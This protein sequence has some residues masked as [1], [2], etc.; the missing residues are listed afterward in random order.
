MVGCWPYCSPPMERRVGGALKRGDGRLGCLKVACLCVP[1]AIDAASLD[2][3]T[4]TIGSGEGVR[5][6]VA[7][8]GDRAEAVAEEV[9]GALC[10]GCPVG[11]AN[12]LSAEPLAGSWRPSPRAC[13]SSPWLNG[14]WPG[15]RRRRRRRWPRRIDPTTDACAGGGSGIS[16]RYPDCGIGVTRGL[17]RRTVDRF[18][19]VT[20]ASGHRGIGASTIGDQP[21]LNL[22]PARVRCVVGRAARSIARRL[23]RAAAIHE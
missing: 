7:D 14:R 9:A 23:D 2:S 4:P 18:G 22:G 5:A 8:S 1:M 6:V 3:S 11:L 20:A 19:A 10:D 21:V 12:E 15:C 13:S 16:V 17:G